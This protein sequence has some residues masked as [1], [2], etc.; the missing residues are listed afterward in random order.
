MSIKAAWETLI[1]LGVEPISA[2]LEIAHLCHS[3]LLYVC[4]PFC[5]YQYLLPKSWLSRLDNLKASF[6]QHHGLKYSISAKENSNSL[7]HNLY[8][9]KLFVRWKEIKLCQKISF[10]PVPTKFKP[11]LSKSVTCLRISYTYLLTLK[12]LYSLLKY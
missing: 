8:K 2:F 11:L 3:Y 12:D 6:L 7:L 10:L 5:P 4:D 1:L 9:R